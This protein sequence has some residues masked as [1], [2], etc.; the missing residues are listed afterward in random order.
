MQLAPH[1][2]IN[3]SNSSIFGQIECFLGQLRDVVMLVT[4][5]H[6][7]S[8]FCI[9]AFMYH[10]VNYVVIWQQSIHV[11]RQPMDSFGSENFPAPR[12]LC[13]QLCSCNQFYSRS[14]M[15]YVVNCVDNLVAE[16]VGSQLMNTR[17]GV[18]PHAEDVDR[19][20]LPVR[21]DPCPDSK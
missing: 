7:C 16:H 18:T 12:S 13:S 14:F 17:A 2:T 8:Q 11:G 5:E 19:N 1:H 4:A 9:R 20:V 21:C 15:Y 6:L 3:Q 10:V